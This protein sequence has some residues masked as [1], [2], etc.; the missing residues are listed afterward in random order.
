MLQACVR[1]RW[2]MGDP[3]RVTAGPNLHRCL[4]FFRIP[5]R[6]RDYL[7]ALVVV[8]EPRTVIRADG[9][10]PRQAIIFAL[11][12]SEMKRE[13]AAGY[14]FHPEIEPRCLPV[15]TA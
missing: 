9:R 13:L 6:F 7:P 1:I 15:A 12:V 3:Y 5:C 14:V 8:T 11:E 2:H 10:F 4:L